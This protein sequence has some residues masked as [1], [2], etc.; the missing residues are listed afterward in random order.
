M[1]QIKVRIR[2]KETKKLVC[3]YSNGIIMTPDTGELY[4]G[5]I[6]VTDRYWKEQYTGLKDK[7]GV[8]IYEADILDPKY[9]WVVKMVDGCWKGRAIVNPDYNTKLLWHLDK[10]RKKAG[11]PL[12]II[13]DIYELPHPLE[14]PQRGEG[15]E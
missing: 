4:I 2:S 12:E 6:N 13:G 14:Q 7:N 10:S 1:T 11:I 3:C 5:G 15:D 9:R 8:E